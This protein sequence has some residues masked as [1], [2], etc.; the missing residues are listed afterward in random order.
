MRKISDWQFLSKIFIINFMSSHEVHPFVLPP[1]N[2]SQCSK[3]K[4]WLIPLKKIV[5]MLND[6]DGRNIFEADFF[7][8]ER[9]KL[10][11]GSHPSTKPLFLRSYCTPPDMNESKITKR[12]PLTPDWIFINS[13][14]IFTLVWLDRDAQCLQ[15]KKSFLHPRVL[16]TENVT[17]AA[18]LFRQYPRAW[19]W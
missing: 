6:F 5:E 8:W 4:P 12:S 18:S 9:R 15:D 2:F 10:A 13:L 3:K 17:S 16:S 11:R 1:A 14:K 19:V 7:G